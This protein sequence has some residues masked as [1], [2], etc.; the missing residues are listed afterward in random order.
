M[1]GR[2]HLQA[3]IGCDD[4]PVT[5][6]W[7]KSGVIYQI[8]PRSLQ[9]TDG[10]GVGD[11][12]GISRRL[13][14]LTGLGVDA[15]WISPIY[16][17]PMADFGYDVS[18]YCDIDPRFGTLADFDDLLSQAHARGLKV[19]LDFVPNH[20]SDQHPWFVE[21]R[22][23]RA[24]PKRDWYLWRDP[25]PGGGPPNNWISDFG[26]PAWQWD[27]ASGQYYYH[28][29]LKEQPDLNW[30]NPAV[31]AAMHDVLRFWLDRGV[32]G[33]RVDVLWHLVKSADFQDNPPN[34]AYRPELGEMHRVLQLHSTDQPE[35]HDVAADMRAIADGYAAAGRGARVLVG[36]IYLPVEQLMAYYGGER[37]GVHLPFNFQLIEAPWQARPLA[38]LI[39]SYEAALPQG[40]WPSWV[41][42]NHDRPRVATRRGQAQARI[43]AMLLL[44]L[45]GTPTLYYGDE[46]GLSDV[47]IPP[48]Q[49]QDP[50]ELRQPSKGLGRDPMRTP[51]PWDASEHAGFSTAPPWLPLNADWPE[52][53]VARLAAEPGSLLALYRRLLALRR[54]HPALAIGDFALLD[55]EEDVLAYERRYGEE[56]LVV[57]LNLGATPQRFEVPTWAR[58]G[59]PLLSTLADAAPVRDGVLRLRPNEGVILTLAG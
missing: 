55:A 21:S 27:E 50:R 51:M 6:P 37:A 46:L 42:G 13:D 17:S 19:L 14:Y 28:A 44:T 43:A 52:R 58:D 29:F 31:R 39:A 40:G 59:R 23:S 4:A 48:G 2:E 9:D 11:L 26:G 45:R 8:Y 56:R 16:P 20:S 22:A 7:W 53:N 24:N 10:D 25:A 54:A 32:D 35:V 38:V 34:P 41:L 18:D 3:A 57:A 49:V 33:F 30:R 36:E 47:P 12:K 5:V 15:I 1:P